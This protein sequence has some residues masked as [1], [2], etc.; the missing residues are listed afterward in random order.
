MET[1]RQIKSVAAMKRYLATL[2]GE[3]LGWVIEASP[4]S[5]SP[6]QQVLCDPENGPVVIIETG[7][8]EYDIL[9]VNPDETQ[10]FVTNDA[11]KAAYFATKHGWPT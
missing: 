1:I 5:F 10:V 11:A 9:E 3:K 8:G 2:T 6:T 7:P 4:R